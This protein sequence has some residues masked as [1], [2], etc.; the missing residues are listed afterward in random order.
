ME[1]MPGQ[2][3]ISE[4]ALEA[5]RHIAAFQR[6]ASGSTKDQIDFNGLPL[7]LH[8]RGVPTLTGKLHLCFWDGL[9]FGT[10][11]PEAVLL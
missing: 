5:L 1:A 3:T 11:F 6:G 10:A 7:M 8:N 9:V 4:D 2:S